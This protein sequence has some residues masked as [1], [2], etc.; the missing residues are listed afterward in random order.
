[1]SKIPNER[2]FL[3]KTAEIFRKKKVDSIPYDPMSMRFRPEEH[4]STGHCAE[5]A[6]C[7]AKF[8]KDNGLN[9]TLKIMFDN[10]F[11]KETGKHIRKTLAHCMVEIDHNDEKVTFDINGDGALDMWRIKVDYINHCSRTDY[12]IEYEDIEFDKAYDRLTKVCEEHNVP[13]EKDDIDKD[14]EIFDSIR[15]VEKEHSLTI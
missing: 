2:L 8:A 5:F 11:E 9:P 12:K 15:K 7:L 4:Y 14:L 3:E 6:Y 10:Q 1:M 13:F